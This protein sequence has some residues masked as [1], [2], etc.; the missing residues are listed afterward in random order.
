MTRWLAGI[1]DP[2]GR[3]GASRLEGALA[4]CAGQ[5]F[6]GGPLRLAYSGPPSGAEDVLCLFDGHLDNAEE[7][8]AAL[9][10]T[11]GSSAPPPQ[12]PRSSADEGTEARTRRLERLLAAGYAQA[13]GPNSRRG[14]GAISC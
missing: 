9:E 13:G 10:H 4:P 11:P 3:C 12:P 8:A 5:V 2:L 1:F 7:I 14:C 6:D